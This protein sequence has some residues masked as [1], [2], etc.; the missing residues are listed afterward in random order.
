MIMD[1]EDL[2]PV[3]LRTG[4]ETYGHSERNEESPLTHRRSFGRRAALRMSAG[5][6]TG[7]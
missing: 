7:S 2:N 6:E 4:F 3:P 1:Q 5:F